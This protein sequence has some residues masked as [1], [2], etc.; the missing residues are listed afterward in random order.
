VRGEG[1]AFY[2]LIDAPDDSPAKLWATAIAH[3]V[4]ERLASGE[5]G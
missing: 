5:A 2:V 4:L 1:R 3:R